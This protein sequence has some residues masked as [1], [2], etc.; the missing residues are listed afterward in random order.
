M[1]AISVFAIIGTFI[2]QMLGAGFKGVLL[3]KRREVAT[4]EANR[5]IEIA[6]SLSYDAIGLIQS[7]ST[8]ATDAAIET[9]NGKLSYLSDTKWE[10]LIWATNPSGHPFNPH[11]QQ[12]QRAATSLTNHIY[13]S[14]VDANGDGAIDMKRISVRVAWSETGSPSSNNEVRAQTLVN[15]SGVVGIGPAGGAGCVGTCSA[16]SGLT[17]LTASTT[18]SGGSLKITSPLLGITAPISIALPTSTGI[19]NFRAVSD[20]T[21]AAKSATIHSGDQAKLEGH[22]VSVTADDDARTAEPSDPPPKSSSGVL[23][24]PAG[25]VA[26]LL[27]GTINSPLACAATTTPLPLEEGTGSALSVLNA[28]TT[29]TA[30]GGQLNWLLTIADVQTLPVTQKIAHESV[31]GQREV[32][33]TS[34]GSNGVV[35]VLKIPSLFSNGLVQVDSLT[36][37]ASVRAAAGTPSTA[38][39]ITSPTFTVRVFDN[40]NTLGLSCNTV[41]GAGVSAS[42]SGSY[43]NVT[44]DPSANGY[45]GRSITVAHSFT[46]LVGVDLVYLT[47]STT[48]DLLPAAKSPGGGVLGSNGERRWSAEYMPIAIAASL[49]AT[50]LGGSIIDTD[51]DLNLGSVKAVACAGATCLDR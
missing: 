38:P 44:V 42:R 32:W 20:T 48:I 12:I 19:S 8:I 5:L 24:I 33:A 41:S 7:D 2:T 28:Q 11:V 10:P 50:V 3:G 39:S 6:R 37:G 47:Y 34:S 15:E 9:R 31:S 16:T 43:C 46:E 40:G 25:P 36:S 22:S 18:S 49:D 14:G 51:V 21:C 13:I 4:L 30:L 23:T 29:V 45:T 1:I 27:G 26:N 35:Q 17:P